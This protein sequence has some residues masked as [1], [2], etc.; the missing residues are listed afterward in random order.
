[1]M[2]YMRVHSN[3]IENFTA[4]T[5]TT[6][7]STIENFT[8]S[9]IL[10]EGTFG[11]VRFG[12]ENSTRRAVA[13]KWLKKEKAALPLPIIIENEI[14][15]M[16]KAKHENIIEFLTLAFDM[17]VGH[18]FIVMDYVEHQ[19]LNIVKLGLMQGNTLQQA[20]KQ[21]LTGIAH[22]HSLGIMHRDLKPGNILCSQ[23]A[24][25]KI[26]DFG[27]A[28]IHTQPNLPHEYRMMTLLYRAP[29]L[30][31]HCYNYSNAIDIW[32]IG[33]I[34]AEMII[35]IPL[36]NNNIMTE[37]Q[38]LLQ[39]CEALGTP[40]LKQFGSF[41]DKTQDILQS[42]PNVRFGY[43]KEF[44]T[45]LISLEGLDLLQNL[46]QYNSDHRLT[47]KEALKSNYFLEEYY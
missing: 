18:V 33:C 45:P 46:L 21:I 14:E 4:S 11:E 9:T 40:T 24:Q 29:E 19:F 28:I 12:I 42:L 20:L 41:G 7:Y 16:K 15:I 39:M 32:S 30:A 34:F 35:T 22:L 10:G 6:S 38:L 2:D 31:V 1:M 17:T 8:M 43:L 13:I 25:I 44:F 36:F 27:Q 5:R 26:A 23:S 37:T 3:F 47:A